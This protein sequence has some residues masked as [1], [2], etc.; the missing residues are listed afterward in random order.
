MPR[1]EFTC[2]RCGFRTDRLSVYKVHV[3]R[4]TPCLAKLSDVI[5]TLDNVIKVEHKRGRKPSSQAPVGQ[6]ETP[7]IV[8]G[9]NNVVQGNNSITIIHNHVH[10][11]RALGEEDLSHITPEIW[12]RFSQLVGIDSSSAME[13]LVQLINYNPSMPQNMN[14][15]MPADNSKPAAVF[16]DSSRHGWCDWCN[17]DRGVA[18]KWLIDARGEQ[19]QEYMEKHADQVKARDVRAINTFQQQNTPKELRS[20]IMKLAMSGSRYMDIAQ[21]APPNPVTRDFPFSRRA[22]ARIQAEEY[23]DDTEPAG[24]K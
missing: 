5:P 12:Q 4:M 18:V 11:P 19:L 23:D 3:N 15:Y 14:T 21:V 17:V 22:L 1:S 6:S 13:L 2:C 20:T 10:A 7:A 16:Y 24:H 8:H 9:N